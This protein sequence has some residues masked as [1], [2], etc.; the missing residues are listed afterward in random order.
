MIDADVFYRRASLAPF[1]ATLAAVAVIAIG[2]LVT[3]TM[4]FGVLSGVLLGLAVAGII[5][6]VPYALFLIIVW[7]F[8]R[9]SGETAHRRLALAAPVLIAIPFAL[10]GALYG[11]TLSGWRNFRSELLTIGAAVLVTGYL[12][13]AAIEAALALAKAGGWVVRK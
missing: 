10:A 4:P 11:L 3:N 1:V 2:T 12:Y 7:K 9:P 5:G 13:V 6:A 8:F